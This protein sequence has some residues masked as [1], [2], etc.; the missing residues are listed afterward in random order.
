MKIMKAN[1]NKLLSVMALTLALGLFSA[2]ADGE[3]PADGAH[4]GTA[5]DIPPAAT[6]PHETEPEIVTT[7]PETDAVTE[8][9]PEPE[10]HVHAFGDWVT[11][12]EATCET[13]GKQERT[14]PC[15]LTEE[16]KLKKTDHLREAMPTV[17]PTVTEN[18]SE[19]GAVCSVCGAVLEEATIL[20]YIGHTGLA[21]EVNA[22]GKTCTITGPGDCAETDLYIPAYIDG[23]KVTHIG[24]AAF[25][26]DALL[27][28]VT[29]PEARSSAM[30]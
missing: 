30:I 17:Q 2:C 16:K 27:T 15:G 20:P 1:R 8:P 19:G 11:V 26:N 10:A 3:G 29:L 9:E 23:Y 14:C 7:S 18:G 22:D 12:R 28:S 6:A 25:L 24:A 4:S 5:G 13:I 21:Y